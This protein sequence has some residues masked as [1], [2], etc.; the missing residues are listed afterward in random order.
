M[1]SNLLCYHSSAICKAS[2][3]G[4][5][6][7]RAFGF[8]DGKDHKQGDIDNVHKRWVDLDNRGLV[9]PVWTAFDVFA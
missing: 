2:A 5:G 9:S 8:G 1:E 3:I 6:W 7:D 4:L